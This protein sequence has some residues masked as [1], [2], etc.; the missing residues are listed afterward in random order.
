MA[1]LDSL[2]VHAEG[3]PKQMPDVPC[4]CKVLAQTAHTEQIRSYTLGIAE[5]PPA[6][7]LMQFPQRR[8]GWLLGCWELPVSAR[9]NPLLITH[10]DA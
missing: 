8:V 5:P 6:G 7:C 9:E 10:S 3:C 1:L 4:S 2:Q